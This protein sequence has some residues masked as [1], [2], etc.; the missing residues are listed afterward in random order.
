MYSLI[1]TA[2]LNNVD[3][4]AWLGDVLRRIAGHPASQPHEFP[5]WNWGKPVQKHRRRSLGRMDTLGQNTDGKL[6]PHAQGRTCAPATLGTYN[7]ARRDL[8]AYIEGFY[9]R[10]RLHSA[11]DYLT[12]VQAKERATRVA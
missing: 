1:T 7:E 8:F 3:P 10:H 9:N 11:L 4:R 5:P 12:P 6:F 2:K